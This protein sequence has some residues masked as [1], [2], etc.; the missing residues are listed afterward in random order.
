MY[1]FILTV[2]VVSFIAFCFFKR[3]FWENRYLVLFLSVIASFIINLAT[4]YAVIS[5]LP[6]KVEYSY[7]SNLRMLNVPDSALVD[8]TMFAKNKKLKFD[9]MPTKY[10]LKKD[11][12][13]Q[14]ML[15]LFFGEDKVGFLCNVDS[16]KNNISSANL[17][18]IYFESSGSDSVAY[19]CTKTKKYVVKSNWLT[20]FSFPNI[21]EI[22]CIGLPPK[23]LA[24]MDSTKILKAKF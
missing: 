8:G 14:K 12:N 6:T 1:S 23:L 21:E 13:R 4:N 18:G 15:L 11:T 3:D 5:K 10:F 2:L 7:K 17:K 20:E 19:F 24:S 9:D 22:K 16:G